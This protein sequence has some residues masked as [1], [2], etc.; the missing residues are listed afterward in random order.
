MLFVTNHVLREEHRLRIFE[1]RVLRIIF[2]PKRDEARGGLRKLIKSRRIR[3]TRYVERM[4]K[5]VNASN[6][7]MFKSER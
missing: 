2:G 4:V 3:W 7:F 1:D 5:K 6:I